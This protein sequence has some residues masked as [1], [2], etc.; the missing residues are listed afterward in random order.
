MKAE[1]LAEA[2]NRLLEGK[3]KE[4]AVSVF[5]S[6]GQY[7]KVRGLLKLYPRI[8]TAYK[9]VLT[10]TTSQKTIITIAKEAD[11]AAIQNMHQIDT[12]AAVRIDETILGGYTIET[13]SRLIDASH[14]SALLKI[15][16]NITR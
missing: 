4:E 15:Y 13:D 14:K 9:D 7:I 6:F 8:L 11:T 16:Q 12:D 3:T 2:L 10:R 5:E 1:R